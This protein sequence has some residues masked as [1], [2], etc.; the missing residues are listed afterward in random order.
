MGQFYDFVAKHESNLYIATVVSAVLSF[1]FFIVL[2][3]VAGHTKKSDDIFVSKFDKIPADVLTAIYG[4]LT[5]LLGIGFYALY[6]TMDDWWYYN[7]FFYEVL[8]FLIVLCIIGVF[9]DFVLLLNELIINNK[10]FFI[11]FPF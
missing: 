6:E 9:V 4:G 2:L 8:P 5:F 1:V 10:T 7:S 3:R 11:F